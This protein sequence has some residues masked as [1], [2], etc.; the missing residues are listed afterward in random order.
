MIVTTT[1]DQP[2]VTREHRFRSPS[3]M[4]VAVTN[5]VQAALEWALSARGHAS[6]VVSGGRDAL[7]LFG[8]LR[9]LRLPWERVSIT[10]ADDY[11]VAPD[12]AESIEG[13]VR[14]ELL[15]GALEEANFLGFYR[16]DISISQRCREL[17]SLLAPLLPFD[18]VL[19]GMADDG[20]TASL[21]PDTTREVLE[22]RS[23]ALVVTG[24]SATLPGEC[25]SLTPRALLNSRHSFLVFTGQGKAR[26]LRQALREG[27]FEELPVRSILHG[28]TRYGVDVFSAA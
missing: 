18:V 1:V 16:P 22:G 27:P 5:E 26:T 20:H 28:H 10:L 14:R 15:V 24:Y 23:D 3:D 6:L 12:H 25:L 11:W 8:Y 19:L 21:F 9:T 7:M 4:A 17:E 13:L 2:T